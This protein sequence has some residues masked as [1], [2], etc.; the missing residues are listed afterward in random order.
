MVLSG[1]GI[2]AQGSLLNAIVSELVLPDK[3][4]TAFGVFDT[5]F[6]I[7]WFG[8]S[9]LMGVLYDRSIL[10]VVLISAGLQLLSVLIVVL[11]GKQR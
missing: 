7:S 4:S 11:I 2:G 6:G 3:R 10:A 8:G 9:W 5:A 1:I